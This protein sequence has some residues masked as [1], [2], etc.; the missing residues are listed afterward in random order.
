MDDPYASAAD[1]SGPP[2]TYA[3]TYSAVWGE[4]LSPTCALVFCHA[5]DSD[6]LQL[7]NKEGAYA[8][9]LAPASGPQC[10]P[11]GLKRIEPGHPEQS[12]LYLKIT[13]PPCGAKMPAYYVD[14]SLD[15]RQI[16]QIRAW[17]AAGAQ[18]D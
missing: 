10:G 14:A 6:F 17:I 16:E 13:Q 1:D 4:I 12:L 7:P 5:G 18:N 2:L 9:L 15:P 3:P 8:S 11:T